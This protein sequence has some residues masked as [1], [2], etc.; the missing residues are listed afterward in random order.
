MIFL[1]CENGR[2]HAFWFVF[3]RYVSVAAEFGEKTSLWISEKGSERVG[4]TIHEYLNGEYSTLDMARG[5]T[6]RTWFSEFNT[7]VDDTYLARVALEVV[8][9]LGYRRPGA[10]A[11]IGA[12]RV[13]ES[14][15]TISRH[16][17][18]P[19][20]VGMPYIEFCVRPLGGQAP[21]MVYDFA[22]CTVVMYRLKTL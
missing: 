16:P 10:G 1:F 12:G 9:R 22:L 11:A 18:L 19:A 15:G 2:D 20:R 8:T 6:R 17:D 5:G 3:G 4:V 7:I 14:A 21:S 13:S